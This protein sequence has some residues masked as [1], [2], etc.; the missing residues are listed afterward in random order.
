MS[1]LN[2]FEKTLA[3]RCHQNEPPFCQAACPFQLDI[4][5]LED[6]WKKGRYNAAYR[7]YQNTVGFPKIVSEIC[8]RP[9]EKACIRAQVDGA[10]SLGLLEKATLDFAKRKAPNAYHLPSKGKKI[11]VI[12]GGL[13][14][15]GCALR[16]CNK[17]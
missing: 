15:L 11:A 14:G 17:K 10:V 12:G 3:E 13:S 8:D 6:K 7:T 4:K 16:L 2:E 9:C 5:D 1:F